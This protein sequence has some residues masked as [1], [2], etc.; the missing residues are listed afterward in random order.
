MSNAIE[1]TGL[2]KR[3]GQVLAL[4]NV[5]LRLEQGKI[6]GLL[7]RNGAGKSTLLNLITNRIFPDEGSVQLGGQDC[8]NNDWALGQMFLMS[9]AN[10]F[11]E[12]MRVRD[13]LRWAPHF[14]PGFDTAQA[15]DLAQQFGLQIKS[16]IKALSTGYSSI[17]KLVLGLATP[18]PFLLLDEPVLG[19][20]ANHRQLF[21]RCLL[22]DYAKKERCILLS[23]HLI[24]E[25]AR[26][27]EQVIIIKEGRILHQEPC[28]DLLARC[29]CITGPAQQVEEFAQGK[30]VLGSDTLG[31][32]KSVYLQEPIPQQLP[33]GL[34]A[35]AA[36]LQQL[37]ISMTNK[38]G[39]A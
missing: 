29:C 2:T 6:Y 13:A 10:L 37:F 38:G 36:D 27:I 34:T 15:Q 39:R 17:F 14:Y 30:Q 11:P 5:S 24:E 19:L 31:G 22:E 12:D 33:Q 7:G 16:K 25:V 3:Y 35:T 26:V 20:D 21:Y 4:D 1:V 23:T 18:V 32:L 8:Q 9:E 28:E